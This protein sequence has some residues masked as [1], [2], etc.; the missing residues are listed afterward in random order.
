MNLTDEATRLLALADKYDSITARD[1]LIQL[2]HDL[3]AL[4]DIG[5]VE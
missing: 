1:L 5:V 4:R 3:A 2:A